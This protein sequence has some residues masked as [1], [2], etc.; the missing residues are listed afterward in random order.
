MAKLKKD[1]GKTIRIATTTV[2]ELKKKSK[3]M[4]L[5]IDEVIQLL[6]FKINKSI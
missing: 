6:L 4:G 2:A 3:T 1:Y 5:T